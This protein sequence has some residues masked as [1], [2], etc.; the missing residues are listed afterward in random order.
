MVPTFSFPAGDLTFLAGAGVGPEE[1]GQLLAKGRS[2]FGQWDP[3][4][5]PLGSGNARLDRDRS[6]AMVAA[7]SLSGE[8]SEESL[9][10]EVCLDQANLPRLRPVSSR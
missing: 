2:G 5:R 4:L 8:R 6:S 1:I 9:L 7:Y 3:V 10:L